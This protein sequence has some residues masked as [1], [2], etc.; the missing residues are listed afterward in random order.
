ME[1]HVQG[2]EES[3]TINIR[4]TKTICKNRMSQEKLDKDLA[5]IRKGFDVLTMLIEEN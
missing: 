1:S 3:Y 5:E 4:N 2:S